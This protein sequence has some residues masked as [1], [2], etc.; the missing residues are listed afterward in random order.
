MGKADVDLFGGEDDIFA[1]LAPAKEKLKKKVN[2]GS[3][4]KAASVSDDG[5]IFADAPAPAKKEA[6]KAKEP[7]KAK[8]EKREKNEKKKKKVVLTTFF[9]FFSFFS[10]FS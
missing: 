1:D 9:F 4:K 3:K 7:K 8:K 6:P 5:D 2:K 10:F